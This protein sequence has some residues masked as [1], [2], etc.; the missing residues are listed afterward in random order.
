MLE[1]L[2]RH[3]WW[4][5]MSV[6]VY[7]YLHGCAICQQMKPNTDLPPF[8]GWNALMVV[9]DHDSM[10][11]MVLYPTNKI[12]DAIETTLLYHQHVYKCFGLPTCIISDRGPQFSAKVFQKLTRLVGCKSS[13]STAYHPQTDGGTKWMNQ[14]IE[15]YL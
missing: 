2:R 11:G 5:D 12:I 3:Y 8:G 10:K 1:L 15:A 4:P 13:M 9:A 14:E 6:F 7:N